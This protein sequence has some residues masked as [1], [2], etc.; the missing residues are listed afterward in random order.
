MESVL[1]ILDMGDKQIT[2]NCIAP[3]G[4][5]TDMYHRVCREYIPGGEQLNDAQVD[6]VRFTRREILKV[7]LIFSVRR[8]LES[9][10]QSWSSN[11]C[12]TRGLLP[13]QPGRRV[14]QRKGAGH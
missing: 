14:D 2:V 7:K 3:G 9:S 13:R 8:H 11:R 6:E 4:I 10:S 5:K 1:T 12:S